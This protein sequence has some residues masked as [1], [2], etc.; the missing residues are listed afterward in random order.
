MSYQKA[1]KIDP[2]KVHIDVPLPGLPGAGGEGGGGA[3]GLPPLR[4]PGQ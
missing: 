3:P 1:V 2:S 4:L